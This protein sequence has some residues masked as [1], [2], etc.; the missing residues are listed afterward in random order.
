VVS[1]YFL[2]LEVM[3]NLIV[4]AYGIAGAW[5]LGVFFYSLWSDIRAEVILSF[6]LRTLSAVFFRVCHL[7]E[8]NDISNVPKGFGEPRARESMRHGT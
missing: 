5:A 4:I 3:I 6:A 1:C 2:Y 8:P 7:H